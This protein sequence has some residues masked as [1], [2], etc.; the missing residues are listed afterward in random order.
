MQQRVAQGVGRA[1]ASC[2]HAAMVGAR[3]GCMADALACCRTPGV[4]RRGQGGE[5]IWATSRPNQTLGQK[6]SLLTSDCST[7]LI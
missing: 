1:S 6:W 2:G 3:P 7:F 5:P 4:R